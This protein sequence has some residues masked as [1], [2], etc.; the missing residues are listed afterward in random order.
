VGTVFSHQ[1]GAFGLGEALL[2]HH[3][4]DHLGHGLLIHG[5]VGDDLVLFLRALAR[6]NEAVR[7]VAAVGQQ[8]QTGTVLVEPT[9]VMQGL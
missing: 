6:V 7:E 5:L 8:Q 9:D 2:G 3:A 4:L 1:P